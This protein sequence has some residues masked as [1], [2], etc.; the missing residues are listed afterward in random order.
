VVVEIHL[1]GL[2]VNTILQSRHV[3]ELEGTDLTSSM[4]ASAGAGDPTALAA[5]AAALGG[6]GAGGGAGDDARSA[7]RL[8]KALLQDWFRDC[9]QQ[10]E[11]T[12]D[13]LLMNAYRWLSSP[14]SMMYE[15]ALHRLVQSLM[16][17][18][19]L[20]LLAEVRSLGEWSVHL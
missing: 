14:S 20:Q 6:G 12:A 10:Q 5:A 7:F 17:K 19:W 3:L 1:G 9:L 16:K 18:V 13:A 11:V 4:V 15:P 8:C 2:A